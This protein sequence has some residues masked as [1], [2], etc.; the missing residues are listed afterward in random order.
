MAVAAIP[1]VFK[2]PVARLRPHGPP[3]A[4]PL[5]GPARP[6]WRMYRKTQDMRVRYS[7]TDTGSDQRTEVLQ[8]QALSVLNHPSP[9]GKTRTGASMSAFSRFSLFELRQAYLELTG[10]GPLVVARDPRASFPTGLC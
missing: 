8:H 1:G 6:E 7:T 10:E 4:A 5:L 9:F 2:A 3:P